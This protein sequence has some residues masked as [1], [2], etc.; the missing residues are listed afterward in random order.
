MARNDC[1][2]R[3]N[4]LERIVRDRWEQRSNYITL[5]PKKSWTSQGKIF[6][7]YHWWYLRFEDSRNSLCSVNRR[8]S[9]LLEG[10]V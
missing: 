10:A 8:I 3:I 4:D 5:L 6:Q 7:N 2:E 9:S 1:Q